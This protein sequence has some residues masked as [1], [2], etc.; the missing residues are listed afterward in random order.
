MIENANRVCPTEPS[1]RL[2]EYLHSLE[3]PRGDFLNK[4]RE[5]AVNNDVP[6][7]REETESLL[8][9]LIRINKPHSILEIGTAVAY[10][11]IVMAG[12]SDADIITVESYEKRI[13]IAGEN[14]KKA[15]LDKRITL[16]E[17][18]AGELLKTLDKSF[19][20]IFLDAAKAQY[21]IWLPDIM[22]LMHEGSVLIADNVLQDKTVIESRFAVSRRE[23]TIHERMREFLT[24]IKHNDRLSTS[25]LPVGDGVSLSVML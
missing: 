2:T 5:Y 18:D 11:T 19:D 21:V 15:K 6:I 13:R 20:M 24:E 8:R 10:S 22:R 14:I 4:L 9:T 16:L 12:E 7:V 1:D 25:I 23:R 17:E 3:R